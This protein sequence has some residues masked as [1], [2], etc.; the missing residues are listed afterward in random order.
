MDGFPAIHIPPGKDT[1][2]QPAGLAL[3]ELELVDV[4]PVSTPL[5]RAGNI[6]PVETFGR[7]RCRRQ[8]FVVGDDG[9]R[10]PGRPSTQLAGPGALGE[11]GLV[12]LAGEFSVLDRK[13]VV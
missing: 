9:R 11:V 8:Q 5:R 6:N 3:P 7:L 1:V 10:L 4:D 2:V 12:L 13:S